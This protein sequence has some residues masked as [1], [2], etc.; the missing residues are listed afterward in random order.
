M[1][2]SVHGSVHELL[3]PGANNAL[4]DTHAPGYAPGRLACGQERSNYG[5]EG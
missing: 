5:S 4:S 3:I 1:L 2:I